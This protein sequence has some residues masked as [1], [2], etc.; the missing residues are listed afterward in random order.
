MPHRGAALP[1]ETGLPACHRAGLTELQ[2]FF[3]GFGCGFVIVWGP[4][5]AEEVTAPVHTTTGSPGPGDTESLPSQVLLQYSCAPPLQTSGR[6]TLWGCSM[7]CI[8]KNIANCSKTPQFLPV[9]CTLCA[10]CAHTPPY[11]P[12]NASSDVIS[13]LYVYGE[14]EHTTKYILA[15]RRHFAGMTQFR[16]SLASMS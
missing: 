5:C 1:F 4:A 8:G 7:V 15:T 16:I 12:Q 14:H 13:A 3:L 6:P 10:R 11:T 2:R 9:M